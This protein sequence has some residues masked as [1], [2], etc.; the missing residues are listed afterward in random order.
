MP[1]I[2]T[3]PNRP[4]VGSEN[5]LSDL[6]VRSGG[7]VY[8]DPRSA[9]FVG[10]DFTFPTAENAQ[11]GSGKYTVGPGVATAHVFPQLS[12]LVF[13]LLQHQISVGGDPSRQAIAVSNLQV[14]FNTIWTDRWWTRFE[15]VTQVDWERKATN[16]MILEFEGG[17]RFPNNW[18]VWVRPGVGLWG[19]NIPGAYEWNIEV[20]VRR[21]FAGF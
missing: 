1:Y 15:A 10:M 5:G 16:S 14:F 18:G 4:G 3:D 6:F 21:M 7:R 12:S 9:L 11:V 19:R 13:T 2:W 17:H 20:G 8:T